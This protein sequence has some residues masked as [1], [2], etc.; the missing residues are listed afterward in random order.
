DFTYPQAIGMG[1]LAGAV[2]GG[3]AGIPA[4]ALAVPII[5]LYMEF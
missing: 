4:G 3:I 2:W 1:F 5:S